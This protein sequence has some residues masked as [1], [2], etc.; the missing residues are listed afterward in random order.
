MSAEEVSL[1][2]HIVIMVISLQAWF[3]YEVIVHLQM[4]PYFN[5]SFIPFWQIV[6]PGVKNNQVYDRGV[7]S[8]PRSLHF[9]STLSEATQYLKQNW[10][11]PTQR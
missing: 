10:L 1:H 4:A 8:A 3:R 11:D 6:S 5:M 2:L 9:H 7:L